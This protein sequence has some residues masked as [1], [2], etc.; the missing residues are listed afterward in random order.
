MNTILP[1]LAFTILFSLF[2][3]PEAALAQAETP[4]AVEPFNG[5]NL[6]LPDVYLQD[7]SSCLPLGPSAYLTRLAKMGI[8]LPLRALSAMPVD[9]SLFDVNAYY[10]RI[11]LDST[12][13]APIY[14]TLEDAMAGGEPAQRMPPGKTRYVSYIQSQIVDK[15][16]YVQLKSG[17]WMRASP[18]GY[19]HFKGLVIKDAPAHPFGWVRTTDAQVR[20]A[21]GMQSPLAGVPLLRDD[22]IQAY[23]TVKQDGIDWYMIGVDAWVPAT[24]VALVTPA[25]AAPD[26]VTNGRWVDVNLFEQT[27]AVYDQGRL[28]FAT[29]VATGLDPYFT[30]PGLFKIYKKKPFE[31]MSGAFEA[32]RSDYYYL[33]DVPWTMYFDKSRALHGAYWINSTFLGYPRSHG[34]VNMSIA[35]AHWLFNWAQDGEFVHVW[36]PSGQTP[37]DESKYGNGGA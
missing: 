11:N 27:L 8:T 5:A 28:V 14:N 12:E 23:T 26:G 2:P 35:D 34:C 20:T 25:T 22:V 30:Q 6:C 37:T 3:L 21:P 32:D 16:K 15:A 18:V 24:D 7:P 9:E 1:L 29:M 13:S 17:E 19:S 33:E 10:A 4:A 36:D 31:T